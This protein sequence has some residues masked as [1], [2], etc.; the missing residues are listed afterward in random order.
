MDGSTRA[1]RYTRQNG[2]RTFVPAPLPPDPP[3]KL[4]EEMATLLEQAN[5]ALGRLD[6]LAQILPN[7]ELF[8]SMYVRKE[9]VL[10]SQIEG[11]QASLID[12][13]QFESEAADQEASPD[14]SE[15]VCYI[16]ALQLGLSRIASE[17]ISLTLICDMHRTLLSQGRGA[18]RQPGEFRTV[19]NWIGPVGGIAR[20]TFVPPP[21]EKLGEA[22]SQLVEFANQPQRLPAVIRAGMLHVQFETIHPFLDGNGRTGR[23]LLTLLLCQWK[24]LTQPLLYISEYFKQRRAEYYDRLQAVRDSGD[25]EGWTR[26]YLRGVAQVAGEAAATAGKIV[27]LLEKHCQLITAQLKRTS[28]TAL[29]LLE[30]LFQ[31]PVVTIRTVERLTGLSFGNAGKLVARLVEIGILAE[32]TGQQRRRR[33]R[34][35]EYLSL[36]TT[37]EELA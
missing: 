34:Y 25:W 29:A 16:Q 37:E 20:A 32:M 30:D 7:P 26:F 13:L 36:F 22:L 33:Y 23:L 24:I 6:G 17:P 2:Y 15:V 8:V 28:G 21:P 18:D 19:Q 14:V 1:G 3:L 10:S 31:R 4:D 9:A 5:L 12:I 35:S 11:T 27:R